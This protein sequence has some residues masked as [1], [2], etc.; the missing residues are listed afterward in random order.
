VL[1]DTNY[2][3]FYDLVYD[4][5]VYGVEPTAPV[6]SRERADSGESGVT[7]FDSEMTSIFQS[8]VTP[9]QV[10]KPHPQAGT[11]IS[12]LKRLWMLADVA[13]KWLGGQFGRVR[14]W[15]KGAL[16]R[17]VA[18]STGAVDWSEYAELMNEVNGP[19]ALIALPAESS[20]VKKSVRS[21]DWLRHSAAS[22]LY[23][24]GTM[25]Q[26]AALHLEDAGNRPSAGLLD[27]AAR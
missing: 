20:G 17:E 1:A 14:N 2:R 8:F 22:S 18:A 3:S 9:K 10:I 19:V 23:R 27:S 5:V 4:R 12:D 15:L 13:G 21:G 11:T 6:A 24:L 26:G 7:E 16:G 25:I